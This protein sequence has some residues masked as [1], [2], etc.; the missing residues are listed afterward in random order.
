MAPGFGYLQGRA[1]TWHSQLPPDDEQ[2]I[3]LLAA[4]ENRAQSLPYSKSV[5]LAQDWIASASAALRVR[6]GELLP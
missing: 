2:L 6:M 1:S 5:K 4:L 3:F